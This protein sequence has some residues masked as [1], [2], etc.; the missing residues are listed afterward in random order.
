MK[1]MKF[2]Y[3]IT[4]LYL[5]L[6]ILWILFSDKLLALTFR[7]PESISYYQSV[8]GIF[9]ILLTAAFLFTLVKRNTEREKQ[10]RL[11]IKESEEKYRTIYENAPLA[12]QSLDADGKVVDVN[13]EWCYMLGYQREE[14]IGKR[15]VNFLNSESIPHFET[16]YPELKQKGEIN[17]SLK[18]EKKN[19]DP[20]FVMY[21]GKAAYDEVQNFTSTYCTFKDITPEYLA[22][23]Q[24]T[25]SEEKHKALFHENKSIILL[26]DDE[27][28][29]IVDANVSALKYYGY[30][31]DEIRKLNISDINILSKDEIEKEKQT[32]EK[33]GRDYFNFRHQLSNGEIRNVQVYSGKI[34]VQN[35]VME[36]AVIHDISR[37]VKAEKELIAAKER[38]EES[39][40]L[41]SAFL[42]NMSHEIRTP[43]NGILGFVKLLQ[44]PKMSSGQYDVFVNYIKES[45]ERLMNTINDIIEISKIES[46][47][48]AVF[49]SLID[50]KDFMYYLYGFFKPEA[51]AKNLNF[52]LVITENAENVILKT[53]KNKLESIMINLIKNALK[54]TTEGF[55]EFGC[56]RKENKL[57]FHVR[58]SGIGIPKDKFQ[59]I[60]QRFVQANASH[61]RS[62]EGSGLGLSIAQAYAKSLG[63]SINLESDVGKGSK[64]SFELEITPLENAA[65]FTNFFSSTGK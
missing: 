3:K 19:G 12:Y 26:V 51:D 30:S 34:E 37:Q 38:A 45:S 40:R 25:A 11:T 10:A 57:F 6:G 1:K 41:K 27:N 23:E 55:V 50:L 17:T 49:K 28:G 18:M 58:D 56:T 24:L 46:G 52:K 29:Q 20:I 21:A 63:T 59:S 62:H 64:F 53:D 47:E 14:A 8:K 4:L 7:N 61:T 16:I 32:V 35:K 44:T 31:Y 54:F 22:K 48:V 13:P 2:E 42:A 39:D 33:E 60:F 5:L 65:H 15:F 36:Y 43:M 9:F